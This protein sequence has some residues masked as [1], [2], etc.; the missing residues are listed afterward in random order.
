METK[1]VNKIWS[2]KTNKREKTT[3]E[4]DDTTDTIRHESHIRTGKGSGF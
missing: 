3:Y 1:N 2:L 4:D